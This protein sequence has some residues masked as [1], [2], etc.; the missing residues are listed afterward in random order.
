MI[1]CTYAPLGQRMFTEG[2]R[3]PIHSTGPL[4]LTVHVTDDLGRERVMSSDLRFCVG[5]GALDT[6]QYA[7][8]EMVEDT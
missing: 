6:P 2:R 3:Y 8:F 7:T 1:K 4:G 5:H